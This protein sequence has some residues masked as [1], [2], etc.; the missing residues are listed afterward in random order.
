MHIKVLGTGCA[1]CN[2]LEKTIRDIV[3]AHNIDAI[4]TKVS[5]L[6]EISRYGIVMTPGIVIDEQLVSVGSVPSETQILFWLKE[7]AK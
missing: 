1:K 5:N 4:I 7:A 2:N 6:E 3:A